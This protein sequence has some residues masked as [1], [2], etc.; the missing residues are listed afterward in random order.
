MND[1]LDE[2]DPT[3]EDQAIPDSWHPMLPTQ[4]PI[5]TSGQQA[6]APT[7]PSVANAAQSDDGMLRDWATRMFDA[8][9]TANG[10][11]GIA[12]LAQAGANIGASIAKASPVDQKPFEDLQKT[13]RQPVTDAENTTK[14]LRDY[15][16]RKNM[17]QAKATQFAAAE[18]GRND[19]NEKTN[20]AI[21]GR[22]PQDKTLGL[23]EKKTIESLATKNANKQSIAGQIDA[24]MSMWDGMKDPE[25]LQQ[26]RQILKVLNS[27]EG[28]DAVGAEEARR[29]GGKLE[30]A[31]G[32]FTT[33]NPGQFGRDLEGFAADAK[34]TSNSLKTAALANQKI[35]ESASGRKSGVEL[36]K[37]KLGK[38]TLNPGDTKDGYRFKGGNPADKN[39]W[40]K[41]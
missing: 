5:K 12:Q 2:E 4:A 27:A 21:A 37:P 30:I 38:Q 14:I 34:N 40:E 10:N 25:K 8:Q 31:F 24:L 29:L 9:K 26:G 35:I 20:A 39:S 23:E 15:V 6:P 33:G 13:A 17:A 22:T 11:Q 7:A 16:M 28:Q 19:R 18:K 36:S 41:M 32:G 3:L 1:L